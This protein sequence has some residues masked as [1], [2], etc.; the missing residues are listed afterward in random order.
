[1]KTKTQAKVEIPHGQSVYARLL[2]AIRSCELKPGDRLTEMELAKRL[3][4]SRTPIREAMRKLEADGLV[5][6]EPRVGTVIRRL[7]YSEVVE[8]YE[9]RTVL[10]CTAAS[11]AAKAASDVEIS[12]L[13]ELNT[14]MAEAVDDARR[15]YELNKQFHRGLLDAAKNRYLVKTV[16]SLQKTLLILGASTLT[17]ND[18]AR[19]TINEHAAIISALCAGDAGGAHMAMQK[20]I[21]S[22]L[23][24]RLRQLRHCVPGFEDD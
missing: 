9:V 2:E 4:V 16:N 17:E 6:H 5:V 18:R 11:M 21:Q 15:V 19:E 20:H 22:A 13:A 10:E 1:M 8:L 12:E 3:D 23:R 7:D 14:E 24:I